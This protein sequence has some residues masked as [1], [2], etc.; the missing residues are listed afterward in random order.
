LHF[1]TKAVF[2]ARYGFTRYID[3][4]NYEQVQ[5]HEMLSSM[6]GSSHVSAQHVPQHALMP[7]HILGYPS[8][9]GCIPIC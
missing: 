1:P 4:Q 5:Q 7:S 3:E 6:L 8:T 9:W 2:G